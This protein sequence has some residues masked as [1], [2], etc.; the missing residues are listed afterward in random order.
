[1]KGLILGYIIQWKILNYG[2]WIRKEYYCI[3]S[4]FVGL[5]F[6]KLVVTHETEST[7]IIFRITY[8][9]VKDYS[10]KGNLNFQLICSNDLIIV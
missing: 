4:L 6:I 10:G 2:M 5:Y 9:C 8:I 7:D 1:M 3:I